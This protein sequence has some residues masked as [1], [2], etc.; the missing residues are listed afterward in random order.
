[1]SLNIFCKGQV[2]ELQLLNWMSASTKK[3]KAEEHS[4]MFPTAFLDRATA[5]HHLPRGPQ[6]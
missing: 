3:F 6:D 1:M 2:M 5:P 4:L